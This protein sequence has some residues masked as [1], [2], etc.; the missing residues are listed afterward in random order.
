MNKFFTKEVKIALTVIICGTLLVFGINFL[1]G[2]NLLTPTNYYYISYDNVSGLALSAP[3]NIEGY[4][5][6]LVRDIN[7]DTNTGN[8]NVQISIE[9]NIK[10]PKGTTA[11]LAS[12]LLGTSTISL[13]LDRGAQEYYKSGDTIPAQKMPGMMSA[14]EDD[15]LPQVN[16]ILPKLDSILSGINSMVNNPALTESVDKIDNIVADIEVTTS[17]LSSL[18]QTTL[19]GVVSNVDT[20]LV[21]IK[22]FTAQLNEVEIQS[23][24]SSLDS[25]LANVKQ[26]TDK[27]TDKNSTLGMLF[28]DK[29]MYEGIVNALQS[30]DSL[31]IDLKAHPSRYVHFSLIGRKE[32]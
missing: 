20:S 29:A 24:V 22:E 25:T 19:P 13:M 32:K 8:I 26:L 28:N 10:L 31:L 3:V 23:I 21:N 12:D 30:A 2:V 15:I 11:A 27:M 17:Q 18:M 6:G 16:N 7:Y 4:K 9:D 14:I 5:V 1:K